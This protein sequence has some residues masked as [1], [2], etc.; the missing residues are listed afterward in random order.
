MFNSYRKRDSYIR[1]TI[2]HYD[3]Y[4]LSY[5]NKNLT[6]EAVERIVKI[7]VYRA[8]IREDII[9]SVYTCRH[10]F[11]QEQLKNGLDIYS[12]NRLLGYMIM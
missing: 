1:D 4:F 5:R 7:A 6:S 12:L 10:Y 8:K 2:L 9:A 11:V 3:N